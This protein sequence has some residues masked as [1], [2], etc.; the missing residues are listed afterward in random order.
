MSKERKK[1][2]KQLDTIFSQYIRERDHYKCI[3][4]GVD[5]RTHII[6]LGHLFSRVSLSTRW[7][8][9]NGNAQCAGCNYRHE[10]DFEPYRRAWIQKYSEKNYDMLYVKFS[11][12]TK[13]SIGELKFLINYYKDKFE[14]IKA[15]KC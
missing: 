5:N 9:Q 1:L 6:Q 13:F 4:C 7:D 12:S 2:I 8:E 15:S 11:K 10:F 14:Q 3:V